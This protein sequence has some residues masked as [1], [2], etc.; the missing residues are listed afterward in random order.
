MT[1]NEDDAPRVEPS[2]VVLEMLCEAMRALSANCS[3]DR[4]VCE[5]LAR[6]LAA[7]VAATIA[8]EADGSV[9]LVCYSPD[10]A[11]ALA[12]A[13]IL[14]SRM[15]HTG[16]EQSSVEY[17]RDLGHVAS[18]AMRP[19][20]LDEPG[21]PGLGR[22]LVF[23]RS[24]P[25]DATDLLV[26]E[27]AQEALVAFWPHATRTV[28]AQQAQDWVRAAVDQNHMTDRE[29]QVLAL[30][31][32]GLLATSIASRLQ[33]SPRTVHKHLGNIYRKLG[34]HDRLVAVSLA[35]LHGLVDAYPSSPTTPARE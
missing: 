17:L 21:R 13:D 16:E 5:H 12:I 10:T 4:V 8:L 32:E 31:A 27:R 30:L 2:T 9:Q 33:L 19:G 1:L 11:D 23:L 24:R 29:L 20:D 26:L 25:Y 6:G 18:L 7:D 28:R 35:R 22:V 34:V 14:V 3:A 15:L